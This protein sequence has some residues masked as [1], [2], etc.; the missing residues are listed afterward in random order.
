MDIRKQF[1][2]E[3]V[4]QH[5]NRLPREMVESHALKV[6]KRGVDEGRKDMV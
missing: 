2:R 4:V 3:R 5:W 6:F 1:F